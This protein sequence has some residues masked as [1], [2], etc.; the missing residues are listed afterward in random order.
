MENDKA[1]RLMRGGTAEPVSQDQIF[2][3]ERGQGN[4]HFPCLTDHQQDLQPYPD[5]L[6]SAICD[7]HTYRLYILYAGD[8]GCKVQSLDQGEDEEG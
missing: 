4:M 1:D 2:R 8:A 5:D 7:E 6:Y 3:R